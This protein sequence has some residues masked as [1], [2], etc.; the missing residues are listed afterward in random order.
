[1]D[2]TARWAD[3][4]AGWAIPEPILAAAPTNP[5]AFPADAI[6]TSTVEPRHTPTG[7]AVLEGLGDDGTLLD[8]GCGAGRICGTFTTSHRVV[9]VEP[10]PNLA[11]VAR[12]VGVEVLEGRWPDLAPQVGSAEVVLSTH[13]LYDVADVGPFLQAMAKAAT[14]RVVLEVTDDHPWAETRELFVH[15]HD[16]PRPP[17]PTAALLVDVITEQLGLVPQL[18]RWTRPRPTHPAIADLAAHLRQQLCLTAD[19]D[20]EIAALMRDRVE[21]VAGGVRLPPQGLATMWWDTGR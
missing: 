3:Q 12:E 13:V 21:E 4:L 11:A 2:A 14:R 8:V 9:G 20:P 17:G 7:A 6:R 19:T 18:V 16:L 10:R 1:M 5:Y 15:F